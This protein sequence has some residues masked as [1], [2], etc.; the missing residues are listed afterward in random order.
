MRSIFLR[1]G[2]W[3]LLLSSLSVA[4]KKAKRTDDARKIV[5][6]ERTGKQIESAYVWIQKK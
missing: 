3:I 5:S 6:E 1:Y 2:L 4:C